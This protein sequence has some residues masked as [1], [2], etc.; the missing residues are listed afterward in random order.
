MRLFVTGGGGFT[1]SYFVRSVLADAYPHLAGAEVT[2]FDKLTYAGNLANLAP[3]ADHPRL[4]F[5]RGDVCSAADLDAALPGHDLVVNFAAET[6]VDRSIGGAADEFVRTN[7]LG[8][9]QVFAAA[10]R[11]GVPTV[12]QV[13]TD[14]VYGSIAT[15]SWTEDDPPLP[16]SPYAASKA[17]GDLV[18]RSYAITYGQDV[19]ITRCSN[20]YGPYQ[21]PEKLIP[22]F[23]TNLLDGRPVPLY[24]DGDNVRAWLHVADHCRAVALVAEHGSPGEIYNVGGGRELTNRELT[25]RLLETTGRDESYV[26]SVA[27][28]RGGGHDRRYSV[29][30]SQ[31][32]ALGYQ[33]QVAFED[34]LTATVR[35]YRDNR[36]WWEP[37]RR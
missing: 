15:G 7:V 22:L 2:A 37:L 11:D 20:N 27:D 36:E 12:L 14:E 30:Y 8:A 33:P 35:W 25:A 13:S 9:Q 19:R 32:A 6:H 16:N 17:A 31:L 21:Y 24:G 1:G 5:V 4:R 23:V 3:V 28:P 10:L 26:V 34:G 29:D 18:A